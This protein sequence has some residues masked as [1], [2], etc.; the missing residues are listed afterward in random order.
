MTELLQQLIELNDKYLLLKR[1]DP[2]RLHIH[3]PD[4]LHNPLRFGLGV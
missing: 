1:N 4:N 3:H 2:H